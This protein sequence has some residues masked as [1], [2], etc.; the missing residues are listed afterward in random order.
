MGE[1]AGDEGEEVARFG[2]RVVPL[3]VVAA[4]G[5]FALAVRV[6][7]GEQHRAGVLVGF[8]AHAVGGEYVR[9]VEGRRDAAEAFGFAL[10]AVDAVGAVEAGEFFVVVRFQAH[11]GVQVEAVGDVFQQ[12]ARTVVVVVFGGERFAVNFD[13]VEGEMFGMQRHVFVLRQFPAAFVVAWL[14]AHDFLHMADHD[15][16]MI[17]QVKFEFVVFDCEGWRL[18]VREPDGVQCRHLAPS[19]MG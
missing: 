5:Q 18:V 17:L 14:A 13:E 12:E 2:V 7:V 3:R 4:A 1:V 9:A 15:F 6:A 16:A 10:G 11:D 8:D 19:V